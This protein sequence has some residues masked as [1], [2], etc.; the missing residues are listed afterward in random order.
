ISGTLEVRLSGEVLGPLSFEPARI[1][2]G[3]YVQN[4][5]MEQTVEIRSNT[6]KPFTIREIVSEDSE[7]TVTG[8]EAGPA[9]SHTITVRFLPR[10]D[11][12]R[13]QTH[14]K[15]STDLEPQ[16]EMYLDIHGYRKREPKRMTPRAVY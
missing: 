16:S 6:G 11:R 9:E 14:L 5:A 4:E 7:I 8:P 3:N 2:F 12:E 10:Q 13:V 1:L 15:I